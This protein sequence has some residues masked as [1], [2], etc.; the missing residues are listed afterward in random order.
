MKKCSK[1]RE[2]LPLDDFPN[3]ANRHDGKAE[4]CKECRSWGHLMRRYKLDK[5]AYS[6][7]VESQGGRCAIC[8]TVPDGKLHVDHNHS[9]CPGFNTCG[10][11]VRGLLCMNCNRGIGHMQDDVEILKSAVKYLEV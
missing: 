1:C 6:E 7:L 4:S 9:C 8:G 10:Q 3:H 11:C 2:V 5:E